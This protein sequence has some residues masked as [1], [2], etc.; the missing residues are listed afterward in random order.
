MYRKKILLLEDD[1]NYVESL[2]NTLEDIYDIKIAKSEEEFWKSFEPFLFDLLILD[3]KIGEKDSGIE[4]LEKIKRENE[5]QPVIILTQYGED[6]YFLKSMDLGAELFLEKKIFEPDLI[7]KLINSVI[8]H[9][10]AKNRIKNLQKE[11]EILNPLDIIGNSE[12]IKKVKEDLKIVAQEGSITCLILGETGVGKELVARNIH[13]LGKRKNGRFIPVNISGI[14][15]ELLY[16]ELFGY[17]KGA[18]TDA[19]E[20]R[21]GQIEEAEGGVIF[22]D[23]IGDLDLEGQIK[24]LRVLDDKKVKRLGSSREIEVDVQFLF[25]TNKN[26]NDFI[27]NGKFREDLFYR[28]REFEIYIPPLRERKE[29]I[30]LLCS[31][32]LKVI[33]KRDDLRVSSEVMSL[34]LKY[35]WPGNVRE[36]KAVLENSFIRASYSNS[37]VIKTSHLPNYFIE[38]KEEIKEKFERWEYDFNLAKAEIELL[39]KAMIEFKTKKKTKLAQILHYPNRFTFMRRILRNFEKFP[40]L[41]LRYPEI[42]GLFKGEPYV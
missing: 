35:S 31:H 32:F 5:S 11:I 4:I 21:K 36:L 40:E 20:T 38:E 34:F 26:L 8:A 19:K 13:K 33:S 7:L 25:A 17:E 24:L 10:E 16:S 12:K 41:K 14:P 9:S 22:F 27:K 39:E 29:D 28:I 1:L 2:K 18:F 6:E 42:Y 23:E 3:I 37:N 30:P 15:K